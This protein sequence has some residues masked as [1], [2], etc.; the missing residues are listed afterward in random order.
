[1]QELLH[2][3]CQAAMADALTSCHDWHDGLRNCTRIEHI[4]DVMRTCLHLSVWLNATHSNSQTTSATS[5]ASAILAVRC[6]W[7]LEACK[8]LQLQLQFAGHT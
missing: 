5:N 3:K 6:R 4:S 8:A 7:L 2:V 1:M